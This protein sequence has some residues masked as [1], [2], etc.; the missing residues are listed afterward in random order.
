VNERCAALDAAWALFCVSLSA[1]ACG[2]L[3]D[4]VFRA[5]AL[6]PADPVTVTEGAFSVEIP[7]TLARAPA[8]AMTLDYELV[9]LEA[10]NDCQEPDFEAAAGQVHF[11]A[12][13]TGAMVRV[14]IG[15]DALAET[16]ERF[17]LRVGESLRVV[18]RILDD[19]RGALLDAS[20][21]GVVRGTTEDQ[22]PA[23]QAALDD[24]LSA[25]R[26]VVL[27][28][29]GEYELSSVVLP[30][31]VTLS[32]RGAVFRRPPR[33]GDLV[34]VSVEHGGESDALPSLIEGASF[35]GRREEQGAYR[36][37]ERENAHLIA[38][39]G[40]ATLGGRASVSIE[41]VALVS[42]TASG[43]MVG[44]DV[45]V[46]LCG[47]RA[48]ELWRDA[49]TVIG[50]ATRVRL[51][52]LDAAATEGTGLWVGPRLSGYAEDR[53]VDAELEDVRIAAGDVELE[54]TPGSTLNVRRLTMTEPPFRLDARDGSVRI[55]DS[56]LMFGLPSDQHNFVGAPHDVEVRDST[57]IVSER[58]AP[59]VEAL[60]E[61]ARTFSA[62]NVRA[63][64]LAAGADPSEP[65]RLSFVGCHFELAADVESDDGVTAVDNT[66]PDVSVVVRG[67]ALGPG[68][69][70]FFSDGCA[71][72]TLAQ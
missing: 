10:Q 16:D 26:G 36:D 60:D 28:P 15:D 22:A 4:H 57:L 51:R 68:F 1:L 25:G 44:P 14:F 12:G 62:I 66:S 30:Q 63:A 54:A 71:D 24:A 39:R 32:A 49:V 38:L 43:V 9:P 13:S 53:S 23:L 7:I 18:I 72:C 42:G 50:G 6:E 45:N 41:R 67:G 52:H 46:G 58:A 35:D 20:T 64:T 2:P 29:P 19:D 31:G 61:A 34:S 56:V 70:G 59:G 47:V 5:I 21:F 40:D 65:G 17:E 27:V 11:A 48:S 55:V 37:S 33:A 69:A 8:D 3:E